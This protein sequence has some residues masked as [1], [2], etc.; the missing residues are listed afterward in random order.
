MEDEND[1][2][3][4]GLGFI[5]YILVKL[6]LSPCVVFYLSIGALFKDLRCY[7]KNLSRVCSF[8][9]VKNINRHRNHTL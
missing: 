6:Q 9:F 4:L 2:D 1:M 7:S 5:R 8:L 3:K